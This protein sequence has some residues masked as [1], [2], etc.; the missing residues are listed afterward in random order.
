M[1]T[2]RTLTFAFMTFIVTCVSLYVFTVCFGGVMDSTFYTFTNVTPTLGLSAA[3]T[4]QADKT[5]TYWGFLWKS[6]FALII[7]VGIWCLRAVFVELD[8]SRQL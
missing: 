2:M 3:W 6:V 4:A 7:A 1:I 8:Y 5:L